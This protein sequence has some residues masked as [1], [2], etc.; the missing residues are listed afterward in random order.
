MTTYRVEQPE[1]PQPTA[2]RASPRHIPEEP[3][4]L[5]QPHLSHLLQ[6]SQGWPFPF[7]NIES[8]A[9]HCRP[10]P[11]LRAALLRRWQLFE[12]ARDRMLTTW[13]KDTTI[14]RQLQHYFDLPSAEHSTPP[15]Q[16]HLQPRASG[17]SSSNH[18][19]AEPSA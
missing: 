14:L 18:Q 12:H 10:S 13:L 4:Q 19:E 11:H 17:P 5:L 3:L 16:P 8:Y 7:Q 6:L 9:A 1:R 2:R 15:P